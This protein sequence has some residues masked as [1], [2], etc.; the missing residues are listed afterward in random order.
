MHTKA[1][2]H[3][4]DAPS[5]RR[6]ALGFSILLLLGLQVIAWRTYVNLRPL[7]F[8]LSVQSAPL[9]KP[10]I[11]DRNGIP[12]S[13]TFQNDWNQHD[14]IPLHDI[15]LVLQ[16]AFILA[17]DQRFYHH[18]GIDW[19]ARIHAVIQNLRARRIVRGASTI[20]EQVVRMLHPRPRIWWS[21]W[22]ETIE[23]TRLERRFTKADILEFYLNQV[24]YA[25]HRRGVR[26]AAQ[27]YFDRD[28]DT[29]SMKE[30]LALAV[31]VRA[32]SRLDL[33]RGTTQIEP[34]ILRLALQMREAQWLSQTD[35][36]HVQ[37]TV[38]ELTAPTLPV[39]ASHFI[40]YVTRQTP[41]ATSL[42]HGRLHTTLDAVIQR[43]AQAIL[44]SRLR[45]LR[46][47]NVTHGAMLIVDHHTG[48]I[49]AWVNAG[50]SQIDA[51]R[52][53]RQPGSTLKPFLYALALE[54]GWTAATNIDDAPL[55]QAI[56]VG[57]HRYHNYSRTH[58]GPLR[59]REALGNS[60]NVPA[61]R[62]ITF[63]GKQ[64]FWEHLRQLGLRSLQQHPDHYGNGLALGNGEVTLLEL[65]Q[66]YTTLARQ[67][68]FHPLVAILHVRPST[69]SA[70]RLYSPEVSSL[71]ANMLADPQAR[72][73]EFGSGHLLRF[74]TETAVKTGTS[75][76]YRDAWAMGFSHRY[77]VGVWL[78]NLNQ[79]PMHGV[80]GAIGPALVLRATFAELNRR[81]RSE[82]LYLSPKLVSQTICRISGQSATANCPSMQEWFLPG[83]APIH[84]CPLHQS[85]PTHHPVDAPPS[86]P[87][88]LLQPTPGLQLAMDPRI[89]DEREA[90]PF[91]LSQNINPVKTHWY[92]D[93]RLA[94]QTPAT[95]REFLWPLTRGKHTA[96]AH[97]WLA[98]Q[99]QP[100]ATPVVTFTVK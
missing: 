66:A 13:I 76:D 25:R 62:T 61:I 43:Q 34:A 7:P 1:V 82:L 33:S 74:P 90:F 96:Q 88:P 45:D 63:V 99:G 23:A 56:G 87:I 41:S 64:A 10:Q 17:E 49:L 4:R 50:E 11:F 38:L 28:L 86:G 30:I 81:T 59:L 3:Y 98:E 39:D 14:T 73:R 78:G 6:V 15:P 21:R 83:T 29:L 37:N 35:L 53:P 92:V 47:R 18:H 32:P 89:P 79:E 97:V 68:V 12:L 2:K 16:H 9:H 55:A 24:P 42:Q 20:T 52:T 85:Q 44:D 91:Y 22:L 19:H 48:Q 67:G 40:R 58:Y 69:R 75:T 36:A 26:Q 71:I 31:L 65:V 95:E 57:L 80:T 72:Q 93:G 27:T 46:A 77:T 51:I 60:L 100:L 70:Q 8:T 84:P 94:G 54:R 5:F